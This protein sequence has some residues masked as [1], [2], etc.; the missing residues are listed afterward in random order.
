MVVTTANPPPNTP[1]P[2]QNQGS[3]DEQEARDA[4]I[5][6]EPYKHRNRAVA[7]LQSL[8]PEEIDWIDSFLNRLEASGFFDEAKARD[9]RAIL[10]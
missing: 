1:H 5:H 10:D 7:A 4:G 8:T 9:I 6:P 3:N 2:T